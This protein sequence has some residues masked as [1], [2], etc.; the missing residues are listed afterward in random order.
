MILTLL[1]LVDW[2]DVLQLLE[3]SQPYT[4]TFIVTTHKLSESEQE[5]RGL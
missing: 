2:M 5:M 4:P 1:S 3:V